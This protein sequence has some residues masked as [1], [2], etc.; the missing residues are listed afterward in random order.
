MKKQVEYEEGKIK[1]MGNKN[2]NKENIKSKKS[3]E[4][5]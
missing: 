5:K 2:E 1:V 3:V 4:V